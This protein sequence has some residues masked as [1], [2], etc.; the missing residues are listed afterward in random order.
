[1]TRA[2]FKKKSKQAGRTPSKS[3]E[4]GNG[5]VLKSSHVQKLRQKIWTLKL[6]QSPP[7]HPGSEPDEDASS[8]SKIKWKKRQIDME[9]GSSLCSVPKQGSTGRIRNT[10]TSTIGKNSSVSRLNSGRE[11]SSTTCDGVRCRD[12]CTAGE[13][14]Q[15]TV[16]YC[17]NT[18]HGV[19]TCGQQ[20]R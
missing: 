2:K 7:P 4:F 1:M 15:G 10:L 18:E 14:T 3:F 17:P 13:P 6:Y 11:G 20:K 9:H 5:F 16:P 19:E 12:T 8:Q